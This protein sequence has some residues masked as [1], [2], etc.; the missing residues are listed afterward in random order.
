MEV[1]SI[2]QNTVTSISTGN[3]DNHVAIKLHGF[4]DS[5]TQNYGVLLVNLEDGNDRV[6]AE[7]DSPVYIVG[8]VGNDVIDCA[9]TSGDNVVF[10][11]HGQLILHYSTCVLCT[12][13]NISS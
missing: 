12:G 1:D 7:G 10:G 4:F 13:W 5:P 2:Y 3:G 11:D 8:G 9:K 6:E